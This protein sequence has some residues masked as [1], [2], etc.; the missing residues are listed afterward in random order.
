MDFSE[1]LTKLIKE[2]EEIG[3]PD[4]Y[5]LNQSTELLDITPLLGA[6]F[7]KWEMDK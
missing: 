3:Y 4:K 2:I 6:V 1:I 5:K 7:E